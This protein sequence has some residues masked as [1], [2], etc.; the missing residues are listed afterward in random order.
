MDHFSASFFMAKSAKKVDKILY[1]LT[2]ETRITTVFNVHL[3]IE[4]FSSFL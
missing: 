2:V 3:H 4:N 1:L